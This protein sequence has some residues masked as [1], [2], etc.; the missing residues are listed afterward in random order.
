MLIIQVSEPLTYS[1]YPT[2]PNRNWRRR[3]W[4]PNGNHAKS[5]VAEA[6]TRDGGHLSRG[7]FTTRPRGRIIFFL[8]S[9][10]LNHS[11]VVF[12]LSSMCSLAA[13]L[14]FLLFL[15]TIITRFSG[16]KCTPFV[17]EKNLFQKNTFSYFQCI[18]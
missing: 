13:I 18:N 12:K 3:S 16:L 8:Y 6:R 10:K 4:R 7:S 5:A 9:I 2:A 11:Y 17:L 14:V 15:A 1:D